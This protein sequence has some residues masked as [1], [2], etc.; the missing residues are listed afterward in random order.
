MDKL[1]RRTRMYVYL[2][3]II[4]DLAGSE[5]GITRSEQMLFNVFVF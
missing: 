1:A 3:L 4:E 5:K 2:E